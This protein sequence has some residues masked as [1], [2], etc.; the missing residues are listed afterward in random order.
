[1]GQPPVRRSADRVSWAAAALASLLAAAAVADDSSAARQTALE[2]L[3]RALFFDVNLSR[4]RNQSCATCHDPARAFTDWRSSGVGAAASLGSDLASLGDRN[5]PTLSYAAAIPRFGRA[6]DHD[7]AGGLFWDGRAATLEQQA[8]GPPLNPLEMAMPDKGAVVQRLQENPNYQ[9][10][11]KG[12]FGADIFSDADLAF[13]A[14]TSAIAA[15]ERTPFFSPYDSRYDRYLRGEYQPTDQEALGI[16]LFFSNQFT[17]CNKCHQLQPLPEAQQE[18]FSNYSYQNIGVP[19][20]ALLRRANGKGTDHVDRGLLDGAAAD[21]P[22]QAGKFRVPTLRN[23]AITAPYMHN[24]VFGD[25][26]TVV[27]FYNKF[28]QKGSKAQINPETGLDWGAPE[29]ADN[30]AYDK[31]QAGR[32]LD[33][34]SID[35]LVAFLGML[36]DRRYE[37]LLD[38]SAAP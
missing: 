22:A 30:I 7:F 20:N 12:L 38:A 3:G 27:Q 21:D 19:V 4:G 35:A 2:D 15:L 34:R 18:T 37:P 24:G 1:M 33:A 31:L 36:T 26:R 10:A 6:A 17:N 13:E 28:L 8:G 25:L 23:V 32:A 11:F 29:V 14:M 9:Y 16:T 5:A